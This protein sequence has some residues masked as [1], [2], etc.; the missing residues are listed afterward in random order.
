MVNLYVFNQ[1]S[2]AAIFG[3]GT[4]IREL[5]A[6]LKESDINFHVV[7]LGSDSQEREAPESN[8]P[9]NIRYFH[10]PSPIDLNIPLDRNMLGELY[11]RNVV[12]FLRL[13]IK[14]TKKL[15]FHLNFN[16]SGKLVE[17]LKKAFD[18]K[19][20][21]SIHYFDWC[22]S[23]SG[24]ITRFRK[25]LNGQ[26]TDQD[27]RFKETFEASYR[28]N[29]SFFKEVNHIICLSENAEQLIH[30]D[31]QI[32]PYITTVIYNGL[33]DRK[34]MEDIQVLRQKY[35][36]PDIPIILFVGRLN[37][38]KGLTYAIKAFKKVINTQSKCHFIISGNGTFD[39][40]MKE[41]EDV[42]MHFTWTGFISKEKLYDLYSI[43]DMGVMPSFHEQ[44]SYVAIEMMMHG[45][46]VIGS[47]STGLKEMIVDGETGL[48]IPVM[49]YED[50]VEIDTDLLAEKML[51]LL[52]NPEERM[53]MGTNARIRYEEKYSREVFRK[54]MLNFYHSLYE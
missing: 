28:K 14:D 40:Y 22:L 23:L 2:P 4:Y 10:I 24:N 51:Y 30:H 31:Y 32:K 49:E 37:D 52:Q 44:C 1:S 43:A 11:Y 7:H 42:W 46:P 17:E 35:S 6:A 26:G 53:R 19:V 16:Q 27:D 29:K 21:A 3:I 41:C 36:I 50:R 20:I 13:Q 38:T 18:C 47:T 33:T 12:Y 25:L 45:L 34:P 9:D 5:T 48:H 15:V 54:N 8:E 39:I